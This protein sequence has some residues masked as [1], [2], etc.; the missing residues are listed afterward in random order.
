MVSLGGFYL[1]SQMKSK[2]KMY[3]TQNAYNVK[4][5]MLHTLNKKI[6][7]DDGGGCGGNDDDDDNND[8][9]VGG[10]DDDLLQITGTIC[11]LS[12]AL[13]IPVLNVLL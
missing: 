3:V 12:S 7:D 6:L 13:K 4:N 8:D 2:N 5:L 10:V 9:D 1:R 11:K